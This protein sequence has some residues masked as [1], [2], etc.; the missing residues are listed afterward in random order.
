MSNCKVC[1]RAGHVGKSGYC[2]ACIHNAFAEL[3]AENA[4]WATQVDEMM[5]QQ[6][7][8]IERIDDLEAER[9]GNRPSVLLQNADLKT[10]NAK[11]LEIKALAQA[12]VDNLVE[13]D[14]HVH[15]NLGIMG[16]LKAALKVYG[17]ANRFA[18]MATASDPATDLFHD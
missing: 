12:V 8:D 17:M 6:A 4:K 15:V 11:L 2:G 9:E 13:F 7:Y 10:E 16:N 3:E 5:L 14:Q 1:D 18:A